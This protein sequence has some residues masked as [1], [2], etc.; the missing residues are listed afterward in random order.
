VS[1]AAG[2]RIA[3]VLDDKGV[4]NV[5]GAD[6]PS[7]TPKQLTSFSD[8]DGNAITQL[9]FTPDGNALVFVRGGDHGGNW[10]SPGGIE[11]NRPVE[12]RAPG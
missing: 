7:W 3:W 2:Q 6:G 1:A 8:D 10:P 12:P 4:R 5:W 9:G 11:P